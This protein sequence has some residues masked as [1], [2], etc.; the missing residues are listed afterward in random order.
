MSNTMSQKAAREG[1]GNPELF[2]GGV[3][4]T[5]NGQSELFIQTSVEREIELKERERERQA[6][7][8]L[9]LVMA[10]KDDVKNKRTLSPEE[11]L[12]KLRAARK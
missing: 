10:A 12:E 1:L 4:V 7:A 2:K 8:L 5:K 3:F 11:A 6:N 9:K